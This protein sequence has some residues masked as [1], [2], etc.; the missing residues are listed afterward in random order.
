MSSLSLMLLLLLAVTL[1]GPALAALSISSGYEAYLKGIRRRI[2]CDPEDIYDEVQ[3][4]GRMRS[5]DSMHD[6]PFCRGLPDRPNMLSPP[7]RHRPFTVD[8]V[9]PRQIFGRKLKENESARTQASNVL[10]KFLEHF[11]LQEKASRPTSVMEGKLKLSTFPFPL[12]AGLPASYSK[13]L[14]K[15]VF[16]AWSGV[17]QADSAPSSPPD[18]SI[19]GFTARTSSPA[20]SPLKSAPTIR[21]NGALGGFSLSRPA[22]I[23]S[24]MVHPPISATTGRHRLLV[25]GWKADK[26]IWRH[27]YDYDASIGPR[28][29]ETC[30]VGDNVLARWAGDGRMDV[31]VIL[32]IHSDSATVRW[33]DDDTSHRMVS[34]KQLTTTGGVPC[35]AQKTKTGNSSLW[36][37]LSRKVKS[38]DEVTFA[39]LEGDMGWMIGDLTVAV[40]KLDLTKAPESNEVSEVEDPSIWVIQVHPGPRSSI[41]QASKAALLFH[42]DDMLERG[43]QLRTG[44]EGLSKEALAVAVNTEQETT[45]SNAGI[46]SGFQLDTHRSME[47]LEQFILSL[48]AEAVQLPPH[49]STRQILADLGTLAYALEK[50]DSQETFRRNQPHFDLWFA[51]QWDIGSRLEALQVAYETWRQQL[52]RHDEALTIFEG[53]QLWLG[54]YM[55]TQGLSSLSLNITKVSPA[56]SGQGQSIE[57]DLKFTVN[58]G[59]AVVQGVY[60]VAGRLDAMGQEVSLSPVPNSW[61][62][63]PDG[64]GMVGLQGVV[65][66]EGTGPSPARFAGLVPVLGCDAFELHSQAAKPT[67]QSRKPA[68]PNSEYRQALL[69][70]RRVFE[71]IRGRWRARLHTFLTEKAAQDTTTFGASSSNDLN[72]VLA[73]VMEAAR[74]GG[75]AESGGIKVNL[76]ESLLGA[77][78]VQV[79]IQGDGDADAIAAAAAAGR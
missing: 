38:V 68:A 52:S 14:P 10:N 15:G 74:Q 34:W 44:Q 57:A 72:K 71:E 60:V 54:N 58:S 33:L 45:A 53:G 37:E 64:F 32:E 28:A 46:I 9:L 61:K 21:L 16:L 7:A 70:W 48:A 62:H 1:P 23:R 8:S 66:R 2:V 40:V 78:E 43:L 26:E 27:S 17:W 75:N 67:K 50:Q 29:R 77:T 49:L 20:F 47:G 11:S 6:G 25:R 73:I 65:S 55:C 42:A 3:E 59:E 56:T 19:P 31:A 5:C 35:A 22:V 30:V 69:R 13:G 24:L 79:V 18:V 63:E 4:R 51:Y 36:R 12:N 41:V 76:V 39:V